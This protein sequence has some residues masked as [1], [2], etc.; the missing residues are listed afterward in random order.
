MLNAFS[1]TAVAIFLFDGYMT[2]I[3]KNESEYFFF[4]SHERDKTGMPI[5]AESGTALLMHFSDQHNLERHICA[6]ADKLKTT[7]FETVPVK[8]S[9]C[10]IASNNS[11]FVLGE[12]GGSSVPKKND[13]EGIFSNEKVNS[14]NLYKKKNQE[15]V[16]A[17][18]KTY[19]LKRKLTES[20][21]DRE[22][23][24]A[25]NRELSGLKKLNLYQ[26]IILM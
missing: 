19:Y 12:P 23:R 25:K 10:S 24:L 2:A 1:N 4:D 9:E 15:K 18:E 20:P 26:G 17:N 14:Q 3:I 11:E 7:K 8:I 22:K 21:E 6:L 5:A 13:S 16:K